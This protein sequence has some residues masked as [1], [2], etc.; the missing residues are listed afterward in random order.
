MLPS[1]SHSKLCRGHLSATGT[2]SNVAVRFLEAW[3]MVLRGDGRDECEMIYGFT[4]RTSGERSIAASILH[5][6]LNLRAE[7]GLLSQS[8]LPV[9]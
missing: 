4:F 3:V 1:N 2:G 6:S 8:G 9:R 7:E 5:I